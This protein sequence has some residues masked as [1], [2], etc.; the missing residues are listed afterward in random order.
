MCRSP[1]FGAQ[2]WGL[3]AAASMSTEEVIALRSAS[4]YRAHG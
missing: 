3:P 2:D 1:V 4:A